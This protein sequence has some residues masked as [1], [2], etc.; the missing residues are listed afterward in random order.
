[1]PCVNLSL[2]ESAQAGVGGKRSVSKW[3]RIRQGQS[4]QGLGGIAWTGTGGVRRQDDSDYCQRAAV[5]V[6]EGGMEPLPAAVGSFPPGNMGS[7][8][9]WLSVAAAVLGAIVVVAAG[10]WCAWQWRSKKA[11]RTL[12]FDMQLALY[13]HLFRLRLT[14]L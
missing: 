2:I 10:C 9:E 14:D 12:L 1:M 8:L 7:L 5:E 11:G 3:G 13:E 4:A 6:V